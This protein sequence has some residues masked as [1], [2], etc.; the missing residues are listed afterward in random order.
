MPLLQ[1][2]LGP[3][4][5]ALGGDPAGLAA[6]PSGP[7]AERKQ[8][9]L[10]ADADTKPSQPVTPPLCA[11]I[12]PLTIGIQNLLPMAVARVNV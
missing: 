2:Q 9:E 7:H 3:F 5:A 8:G 10:E 1:P 12:S 4:G 6:S 11:S